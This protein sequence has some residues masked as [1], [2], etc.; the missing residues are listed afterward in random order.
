M[1]G[2]GSRGRGR[3]RVEPR[4]VE[5]EAEVGHLGVRRHLAQLLHEIEQRG[6]LLHEGLVDD[7]RRLRVDVQR[8]RHA[9]GKHVR[10]RLRLCAAV[11]RLAPPR[12]QHASSHRPA[13]RRRCGCHGVGGAAHAAR[14]APP[15][16]CCRGDAGGLGRCE[17]RCG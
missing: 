15:K 17:R 1:V 7:E 6:S 9:V 8:V 16:P 14:A 11:G 5:L 10:L 3:V 13:L 12:A 4:Q 2:G